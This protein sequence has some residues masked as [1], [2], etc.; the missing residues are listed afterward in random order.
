MLDLAGARIKLDRAQLQLLS[1]GHALMGFAESEPYRLV[2]E[3]EPRDEDDL[4]YY[5]YIVT[6]LRP[7]RPE[8]AAHIGEILHNFRSA[9]D[10]LVYA[11]ATR[12]S[13]STQF[14]IFHRASD[15]PAKSRPMLR[16]VPRRYV[17]IVEESQPY[18]SSPPGEH[19]LSQLN[20]LSN[21][22]KH[23]LLNTT[24]TALSDAVPTF[25]PER[26]VAAIHDVLLNVGTLE[27]GGELV[28][29]LIEPSGPYPAV[30]M[31]GVFRLAIT[32]RDP[33]P[34]ARTVNGQSVMRVLFDIGRYLEELYEKFARA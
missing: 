6:D 9:L 13:F 34:L 29:L 1:L 10:Y 16:A 24:A 7:T 33:A 21:T 27:E 32:F 20:Y 26:D 12:H 8:Y 2:E 25:L 31:A 30:E 22:D 5:R 23:R 17:R 3:V 28:R 19:V 4:A 14:P 15:W 18:H 11:A